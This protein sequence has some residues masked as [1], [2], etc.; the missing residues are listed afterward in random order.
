MS[1]ATAAPGKDTAHSGPWWRHPYMWLVVGGPAVVVV[2]GFVTLYLAI[3]SPDYVYSD[4]P[5]GQASAA[6]A[7]SGARKAEAALAP[8]MQARNHAATGGL[9]KPEEGPAAAPDVAASRP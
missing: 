9:A 2:A 7:A 3:R 4:E 6:Q 8:A 5:P 1:K